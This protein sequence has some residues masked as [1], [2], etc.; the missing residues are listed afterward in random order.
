MSTTHDTSP[1][2]R[3][4]SAVPEG[5]KDVRNTVMTTE[6][7]MRARIKTLENQLQACRE[8]NARLQEALERGATFDEAIPM[9]LEKRDS[10]M[11]RLQS[12]T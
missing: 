4:D 11:P 5:S 12:S 7:I 2:S 1:T 10:E 6:E 9:A 3:F 8:E